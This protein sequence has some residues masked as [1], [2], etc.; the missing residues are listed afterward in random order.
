M[1]KFDLNKENDIMS[2]KGLS[3]LYKESKTKKAKI[4]MLKDESTKQATMDFI[5]GKSDENPLKGI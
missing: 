2:R 4:D 5:F 3:D 1:A